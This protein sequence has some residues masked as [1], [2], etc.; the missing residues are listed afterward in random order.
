MSGSIYCLYK[1]M[2]YPLSL[3]V[4]LP[5]S[6]CFF[7]NDTATTEIYTLS[8]HDA[9]PISFQFMTSFRRRKPNWH[10]TAGRILVPSG[11]VAALT[12]VWMT[13][14]YPAVNFDGPV[15]YV[16]R[17]LVGSAMTL[18]ICL[19]FAAILKRNFSYHRAWMMRSYALGFG[20]CTQVLTHIPWALFPSIRGELA[21]TLCMTAG[22][23]INIIVAE[24]ILMRERRN[25]LPQLD[26]KLKKVI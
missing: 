13:Q 14:Y 24:W 17:L 4:S 26:T 16:I 25:R 12:G 11:I 9:L 21:R 5:I 15:L 20:A 6:F 18:F 3:L 8:L 2:Y 22:W 10:R 23:V 1:R 19:G 7:F